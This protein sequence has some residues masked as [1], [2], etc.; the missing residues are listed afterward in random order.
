MGIFNASP[1]IS[2]ES[3]WQSQ[4]LDSHLLTLQPGH[5]PQTTFPFV[6]EFKV[7]LQRFKS[8]WTETDENHWTNST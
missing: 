2:K 8:R 5:K 4:D 1:P 3:L 6:L 7:R